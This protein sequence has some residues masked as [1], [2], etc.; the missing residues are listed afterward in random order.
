M[1]IISFTAVGVRLLA[2]MMFFYVLRETSRMITLARSF[3]SYEEWS[4]A[5]IFM[6]G[7]VLIGV[8]LWK[9][10]INIAKRLVPKGVSFENVTPNDFHRPIYQLAFVLLG[11]YVL[12]YGVSEF[13]YTAQLYFSLPDEYMTPDQVNKQQAVMVSSALEVFFGLVLIIGARGVSEVIHKIRYG[14]Q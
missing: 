9:Y 7:F 1:N 14:A 12:I 10:A 8:W 5:A 4:I 2:L 6:V 3:D 13:S 11:M